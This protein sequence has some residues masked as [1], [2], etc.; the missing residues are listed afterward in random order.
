[1]KAAK[2]KANEHNNRKSERH[3]G[4]R[5]GKKADRHK[6]DWRDK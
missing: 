5:Q 2:N 4:Q 1:M 6:K 3:K